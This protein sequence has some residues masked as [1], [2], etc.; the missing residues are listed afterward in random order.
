MSSPSESVTKQ[1]EQITAQNKQ[2]MEDRMRQAMQTSV[3][4]PEEESAPTGLYS[5]THKTNQ[6]LANQIRTHYIYDRGKV[7]LRSSDPNGDVI[8]CH[9]KAEIGF[10]ILEWNAERVD[11]PPELP[12]PNMPEE[13]QAELL[14]TQIT[15]TS[16]NVEADAVHKMYFAAG[17]YTFLIHVPLQPGMSIPVPSA[18]CFANQEN[19]I[20]ETNFVDVFKSSIAED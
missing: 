18:P 12:S 14:N 11:I 13:L 6:Y 3:P 4:N 8:T 17:V 19:D 20:P 7:I 5:A 9:A 15:I 16:I 2:R 10:I 1:I